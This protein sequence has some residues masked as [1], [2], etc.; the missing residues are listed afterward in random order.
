MKFIAGRWHR[1]ACVNYDWFCFTTLVPFFPLCFFF[2]TCDN[3]LLCRVTQG[4]RDTYYLKIHLIHDYLLQI[5]YSSVLDSFSWFF[6]FSDFSLTCL[7]SCSIL[8]Q[9][10]SRAHLISQNSTCQI[11]N[12]AKPFWI[13]VWK[14]RATTKFIDFQTSEWKNIHVSLEAQWFSLFPSWHFSKVFFLTPIA[15]LIAFKSD[16]NNWFFCWVF[17]V[18]VFVLISQSRSW[19]ESNLAALKT[20]LWWWC[21]L[22]LLWHFSLYRWRGDLF[23]LS[24]MSSISVRVSESCCVISLDPIW[25]S[26]LNFAVLFH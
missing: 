9:V 13:L 14:P 10:L 5:R 1:P 12:K 8:Q 4:S 18:F 26:E 3:V 6:F 22:W 17:F 21:L 7:L 11:Y 15:R 2:K 23:L 16:E 25:V 20:W 24:S 19:M